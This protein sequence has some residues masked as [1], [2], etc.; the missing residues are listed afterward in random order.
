MVKAAART[1]KFDDSEY[2]FFTLASNK[3]AAEDFVKE[4]RDNGYSA[5][6]TP[7]AGPS[8]KTLYAV[9]RKKR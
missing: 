1:R 3:R 5:R 2:K 4:E 8:G 7:K 9:Y 6:F